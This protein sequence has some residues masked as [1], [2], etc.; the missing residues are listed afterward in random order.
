MVFAFSILGITE[1][2][3]YL[4]KK[5]NYPYLDNPIYLTPLILPIY[6]YKQLI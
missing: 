6:L 1:I 5:I 3:Y 4:D 2:Y